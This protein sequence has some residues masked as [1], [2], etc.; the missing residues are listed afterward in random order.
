MMNQF[1]TYLQQARLLELIA[2][3]EA[4]TLTGPAHVWIAHHDKVPVP[5]DVTF[6][7]DDNHVLHA[8][9]TLAGSELADVIAALKAEGFRLE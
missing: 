8:T 4:A 2:E 9:V 6:F 3:F 1:P 7:S 5:H